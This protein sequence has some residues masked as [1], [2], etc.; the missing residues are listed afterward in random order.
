MI[1]SCLF[2]GVFKG[3]VLDY[4]LFWAS[5]SAIAAIATAIIAGMT[6]Y[7]LRKQLKAI[8]SDSE[9]KSAESYVSLI[10][11]L[12][13]GA[14]SGLITQIAA[15]RAIRGIRHIKKDAAIKDLSAF[16][17]HLEQQSVEQ[18][19]HSKRLRDEL[20]LAIEHLK[21]LY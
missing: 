6:A 17:N 21:S 8:A 4:G 19:V 1:D 2:G 10:K 13:T 16:L 7:F 3:C 12:Q 9:L 5:L 15:V 11:T 14:E 18:K 20:F